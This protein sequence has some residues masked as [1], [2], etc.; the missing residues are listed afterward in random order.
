MK[1]DREELEIKNPQNLV[2]VDFSQRILKALFYI[3]NYDSWRS[4]AIFII[5]MYKEY[6]IAWVRVQ[7]MYYTKMWV[8]KNVLIWSF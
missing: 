8:F 7:T 3:L 2:K 4:V 6:A 5:C 1:G